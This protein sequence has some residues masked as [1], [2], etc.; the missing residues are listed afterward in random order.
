[1]VG[2][3]Q[4]C[5]FCNQGSITGIDIKNLY[6]DVNNQ[7][8]SN[9]KSIDKKQ[10][11]A[12]LA[13]FGGS[14]TC[15]SI[16]VQNVLLEYAKIYL[17]KS[18]I[19]GIRIST[20]PDCIN[21]RILLN[22]KEKGVKTIELGIQSTSN[23]VLNESKRGY[24]YEEILE[25]IEMI[26]K[27]DFNLGLQMMIGLPFSDEQSD[28]KTAMDCV[29]LGADFVRVYPTLVVKSTE[30]EDLYYEG[31]Y[32][33]L[34]LDRAILLSSKI[35]IIFEKNNIEVIRLGLHSQEGLDTGRDLVIGPYHPAFGELV[36]SYIFKLIIR[37]AIEK[38][39]KQP[40][41]FS[42]DYKEDLIFSVASNE[43]SKAV[44]HKRSNIEMF[45]DE[46]VKSRFKIKSDRS[47]SQGSYSI[48]SGNIKRVISRKEFIEAEYKNIR[49]E[50]RCM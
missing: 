27:F 11:D 43:I 14:F 36:E 15:L 48:V 18:L 46:I 19:G 10:A 17:D 40:K 9:L 22:L 12:E 21:E 50:L 1:M 23:L 16:E 35:K 7:I 24:N 25:N 2:C 20:R 45:K 31:K 6:N 4:K 5:V 42:F 41:V 3:P 26:K 8:S 13:F 29:M 47:L 37:D 44:G 30:L 32:S 33:P 39:K 34:T 49:E 28:L 38:I